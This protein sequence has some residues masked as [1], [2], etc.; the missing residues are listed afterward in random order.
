MASFIRDGDG[1]DDTSVQITK[2]ERVIVHHER[3]REDMDGGA[4]QVA[5]I[6]Q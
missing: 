4:P 3:Q 6:P 1:K 5:A 2:I